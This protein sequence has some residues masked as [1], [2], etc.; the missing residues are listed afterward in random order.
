MNWFNFESYETCESYLLGKITKTPFTEYSERANDLLGLIH[1]DV[2]GPLS[3]TT[4]GGFS[5]SSL[6]QIISVDMD[7]SI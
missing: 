2:C 6:S 7:M 5:T 3:T 4:R 1:S